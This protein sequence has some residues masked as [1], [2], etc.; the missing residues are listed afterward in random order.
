[1]AALTF[2]I[3]P[4]VAVAAAETAASARLVSV[5]TEYKL[6]GSIVARVDPPPETSQPPAQPGFQLADAESLVVA[7]IQQLAAAT[8]PA[9][10][11]KA[12]MVALDPSFDEANYGCRNFRD[13]L[14]R[15]DHRV[16][17]AGRSGNDITL[18]LIDPPNDATT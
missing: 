8:P 12:K 13:L 16:R 5:C 4:R 14:A 2:R 17:T 6:W 3:D 7:A 9:S 11:V 18:A 15:L 10:Q 1:L